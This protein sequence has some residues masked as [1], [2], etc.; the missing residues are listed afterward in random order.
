MSSRAKGGTCFGGMAQNASGRRAGPALGEWHRTQARD[1]RDLL[2]GNGTERKR[3]KRGTC[4]GNGTERKRAKRGT[5][6]EGIARNA[7]AQSAGPA[8]GESH[9]TQARE[10]R[11]L[12]WGNRTE[13][14]RAKRGTCFGGIARKASARRAALRTTFIASTAKSPRWYASTAP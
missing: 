4:W 8:L 11:D 12:L 9:G 1:A 5:C 2:W 3:E 13:R 14:K 6:F 7:S 10:A